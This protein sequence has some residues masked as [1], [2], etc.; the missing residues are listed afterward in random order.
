[1]DFTASIGDG[2]VTMAADDWV[3]GVRGFFVNLD[4]TQHIGMPLS[5]VLDG[6]RAEVVMMLHAQ[7]Y[8]T[9]ARGAPVQR[10]IGTYDAVLER[11]PGGWKIVRLVQHID[12]DEGN[13]HVFERAAGL[14]D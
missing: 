11:G 6:D 7:H 5:I 4:A 1:M 14:S 8:L 12:W 9:A 13:W 2:L 3:A 10:M